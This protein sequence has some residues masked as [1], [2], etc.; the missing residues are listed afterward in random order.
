MFC[1]L[2]KS[3]LCSATLIADHRRGCAEFADDRLPVPVI[4]VLSG[5]RWSRR[6]NPGRG[7]ARQGLPAKHPPIYDLEDLGFV[8][9]GAA[10]IAQRNTAPGRKLP[11]NT[12]GGG[13]FYMHSGI[14]G[15]YALQESVCQM[16]GNSP[17]ADPGCQRLGLPCVGGMF[18]ASGTGAFPGR[19]QCKGL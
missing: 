19:S 1:S 18:A 9:S 8:G 14:Y 13:L 7:R 5:D 4:A 3:H 11:L 6:L 2:G 15:V 10:F 16:R 17:T 12:N